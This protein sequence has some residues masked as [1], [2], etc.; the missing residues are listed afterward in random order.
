MEQVFREVTLTFTKYISLETFPTYYGTLGEY[1]RAVVSAQWASVSYTFFIGIR[2]SGQDM[3][4]KKV[5]AVIV[6]SVPSRCLKLFS[7]TIIVTLCR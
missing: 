7:N 1:G 5:R 6:Q 3:R 2:N 4:L